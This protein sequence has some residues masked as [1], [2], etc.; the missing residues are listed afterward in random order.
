MPE[1]KLKTLEFSK[2]SDVNIHEDYILR[3]LEKTGVFSAQDKNDDKED[4]I[5]KIRDKRYRYA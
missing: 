3:S 1:I 4:I 2:L 5:I